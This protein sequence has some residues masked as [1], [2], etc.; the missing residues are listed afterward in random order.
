MLELLPRPD[1]LPKGEGEALALLLTLPVPMEDAVPSTV[2]VGELLPPALALPKPPLETL[3]EKEA[4]GV[5]EAETL[6]VLD[7]VPAALEAL[8]AMDAV[9]EKEKGLLRVPTRDALGV[10]LAPA[11]RDAL[12]HALPLPST[13]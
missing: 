13:V 5:E 3:G 4:R 1:A 2:A 10:P 11:P 7:P 12:A 8:S 9:A 6:S